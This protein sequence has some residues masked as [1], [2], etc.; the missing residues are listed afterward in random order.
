MILSAAARKPL[1]EILRHFTQIYPL[2][3]GCGTI[4]QTRLLSSLV[5]NEKDPKIVQLKSGELLT[6]IPDDYVGRSVYILE[7]WIQK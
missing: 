7:T 5:K 3:S 6:I 4:A 1:R 2:L